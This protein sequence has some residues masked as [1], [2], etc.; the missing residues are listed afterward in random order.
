MTKTRSIPPGFSLFLD[1]VRVFAALGVVFFHGPKPFF[2]QSMVSPYR[3]EHDL[4]II[5]FVLSGYVIAYVEKEREDNLRTYAINRMS[6]ILSVSAPAIFLTIV[7]DLVLRKYFYIHFP[8]S[9]EQTVTWG[10]ISLFFINHIWNIDYYPQILSPY[11]SLGFEVWFYVIFAAFVFAKKPY[12]KI[13]FTIIALL[14][15]GPRVAIMLPI[16]LLGVAT[17][18]IHRR[19]APQAITALIMILSA[20]VGY[21]AL[22]KFLAHDPNWES[23]I[24][25]IW[26]GKYLWMNFGIRMDFAILWQYDYA[27]GFLCAI[28]FLAAP[29]LCTK[30][31][32]KTFWGGKIKYLAGYTFSIYLYQALIFRVINLFF[33]QHHLPDPVRWVACWTLVPIIAIL[34]GSVTEKKKSVLHTAFERL[35]LK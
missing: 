5:F 10:V 9:I 32:P 34:I 21:I 17:Y 6:R 27:V 33:D 22:K 8:Y 18:Y 2:I 1:A 20:V 7:L 30:I 13:L 25:G 15:I 23:P 3:F 29:N 14:L 19:W 28:I 16:W 11:W 12:Q 4:V 31:S 35:W 24:M 26:L